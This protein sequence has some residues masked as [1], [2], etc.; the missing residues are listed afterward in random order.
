MSDLS[1]ITGDDEFV[2]RRPPTGDEL[3]SASGTI[4]VW[5]LLSSIVSAS[6]H[7]LYRAEAAA[8]IIRRIG[9]YRWVGIYDISS[10]DACVF[11]WT[12]KEPPAFVRFP[13]GPGLTGEAVRTRCTV[14]VNDVAKDPRYLTAFAGTR[15]EIVVPVLDPSGAHV[16]GTIDVESE[17]LDAFAARDQRVLEQCAAALAPLWE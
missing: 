17:K 16:V 10:E 1:V 13:I 8:N 6:S 3:L 7:R 11:A 4:A 2:P 9:P 14:V 12:G 5:D 15:S